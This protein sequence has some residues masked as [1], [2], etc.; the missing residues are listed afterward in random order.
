MSVVTN[1][2]VSFCILEFE[3]PDFLQH[4]RGWFRDKGDLTS[5][6]H[7][8]SDPTPYWWGGTKHPECQ[9]WAGAYNHLALGEMLRHFEAI[10]WA[11]PEFVQIF[12]KEE[13]E[14]TFCVFMFR[15]GRLTQVLPY[16]AWPHR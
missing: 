13:E 14:A 7:G 11:W 3:K 9:L 6:T 5:I 1:V 8:H 2:M 12:V 4:L 15:E 16:V 10:D